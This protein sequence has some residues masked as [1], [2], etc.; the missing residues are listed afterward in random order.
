MRLS[1]S[2]APARESEP[3]CAPRAARPPGCRRTILPH[4][5]QLSLRNTW[6]GHGTSP[7]A[8]P[9]A[10]ITHFVQS[11]PVRAGRALTAWSS[12]RRAH[13]VG[14]RLAGADWESRLH[15]D[16]LS[17]AAGLAEL[18]GMERAFDRREADS[19]RNW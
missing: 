16:R 4:V 18:E 14:G 1:L 10:A 7:F 12:H 15:E 3:R 9:V 6:V 19:V 11:L 5:D 8:A 17:R 13:P 2:P